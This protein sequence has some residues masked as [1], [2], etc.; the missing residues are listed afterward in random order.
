MLEFEQKMLLGIFLNRAE[1]FFTV[2]V[3]ELDLTKYSYE[4]EK[5]Q[6]L[7]TWI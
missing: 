7:K 1:V 4:I 5:I 2:L 6:K 3:K